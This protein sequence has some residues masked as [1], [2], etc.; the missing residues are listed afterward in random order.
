MQMNN[1]DIAAVIRHPENASAVA[2]F[3]GVPELYI[4]GDDSRNKQ[5]YEIALLVQEEPTELGVPGP[6]GQPGLLSSIPVTP[7]LDDHEVEA[8]ICKAWLRSEV[9]LDCKRSNPAGY[10]NVLAHL[11]EHLFFVAQNEAAQAQDEEGAEGDK[12]KDSKS[13]EMSEV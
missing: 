9:G 5:L 1:E 7:E 3:L 4:P 11:K 8:E 6:D 12:K 13:E 2:E 10:A